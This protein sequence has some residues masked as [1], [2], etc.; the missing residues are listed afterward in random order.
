MHWNQ[1]LK[2]ENLRKLKISI[3]SFFL[4][5]TLIHGDVHLPTKPNKS[6]EKEERKVRIFGFL[7]LKTILNNNF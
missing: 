2:M 4:L 7:F 1:S 5:A 3:L 6:I